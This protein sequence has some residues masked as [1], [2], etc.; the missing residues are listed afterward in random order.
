MN[1]LDR[2]HFSSLHISFNG[3]YSILPTMIQMATAGNFTGLSTV[4]P[5]SRMSRSYTSS[6]H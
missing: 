3:L 4:F 1:F 2:N 6:P 5:G